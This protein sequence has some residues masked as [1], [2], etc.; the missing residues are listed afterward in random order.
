MRRSAIALLAACAL[1]A[2]ALLLLGASGAWDP[3]RVY[4]TGNEVAQD[5]AFSGNFSFDDSIGDSPDVKWIDADNNYFEIVK[6]DTGNVTLTN[7]EGAMNL[8]MNGDTDDYLSFLTSGNV[9]GITT[10]GGCNLSIT[11][12][13][14]TI[15]FGDEHLVTTG[16]VSGASVTASANLSF[17]GDLTGALDLADAIELTVASGNITVTQ[18]VHRV[19]GQG[20]ADDNLDT[21]NGGSSGQ[22][23]LLYP[24]NAAR[25]ITLRHGVG[26]L[27]TG[28]GNDYT[29]PDNGLALLLYDGAN[30]RL[31]AGA[32]SGSGTYVE[33]A[34]ATQ[35]FTIVFTIPD[36]PDDD[37]QHVHV[38]VDDNA[39]FAS[40]IVDWDTRAT[41]D[42]TTG[43]LYF[44]G[45]AWTAWPAGGVLAAF[46]GEAGSYSFQSASISR[47][48]RY[49]IRYR[50]HD[51]TGFGDWTGDMA[52]W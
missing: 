18:A 35:Y 48:T 49:Y 27:V 8:L 11:A 26:N 13:G 38:Q 31:V 42:G 7:N 2:A 20:D 28:D 52:T 47:G 50:F 46:E 22:A 3:L 44:S 33:V 37:A 43:A 41:E 24:E 10:V 15:S 1:V 29:I 36:E 40:P 32:G 5:V 39:D 19:D 51:G 14:G 12:D 34:N 23:V 9:P 4:R 16:N 45:T 6:L 30:W 17:A 25:N 21:I